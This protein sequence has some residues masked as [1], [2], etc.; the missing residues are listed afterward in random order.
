MTEEEMQIVAFGDEDLLHGHAHIRSS[1][2][3]VTTAP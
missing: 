3:S 2:I 1:R